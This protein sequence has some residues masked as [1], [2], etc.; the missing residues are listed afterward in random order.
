MPVIPQ[1]QLRAQFTQD[2][3][4]VYRETARPTLFL[5]SFF[6]IKESNTKYISIMVRRGTEMVAIDVP[7]GH[8][9]NIYTFDKGTEKVWLPPYYRNKF[10]LNDSDLYDRVFGSPVV[11]D[12]DYAAYIEEL[13]WKVEE[14][15][16]PIWR[17][18]E[19]QVAGSL[20]DG[21][22]KIASGDNV[23]F[24]RKAG[25]LVTV[26]TPWGDVDNATPYKDLE[27]GCK[28]TRQNGLVT[29]HTFDAVFGS[30]AWNAFCNTKQ[31]VTKNNMINIGLDKINTPAANAAGGSFM[32]MVV[33]GVYT[34]RCWTYPQ[35]YTE[36]SGT[37]K[38]YVDPK[39]VLLIA[40]GAELDMS[41]GAVP[42]LMGSH[43]GKPEKGAIHYGE[44][45]DPTAESH[46]FDAKS[47]GMAVPVALDKLYTLKVL[48]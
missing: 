24:K 2:V 7:R 17:A 45:I 9:G 36:K 18:Y 48:S 25:S 6:K 40:E 20:H 37:S 30:D 3:I 15:T 33:A 39:K 23:D 12:V 11:N 35:F 26:T 8:D 28:W 13:Q 34:V 43:F 42:R 16:N 5:S 31:F 22:I 47:A 29:T 21:I 41:F 32:G 10:F 38:P 44:Y 27:D 46:I 19:L 14:I 1:E 4:S